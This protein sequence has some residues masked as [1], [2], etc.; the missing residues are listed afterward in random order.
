MTVRVKICGLTTLED[1]QAAAD[2]GA[3]AVGFVLYKDSPRQISADQ[4]KDIIRRLPG[5]S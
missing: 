4:A 5:C 2:A 1:A 3:D